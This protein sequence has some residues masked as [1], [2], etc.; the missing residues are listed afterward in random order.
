M[1]LLHTSTTVCT[2]EGYLLSTESLRTPNC[3]GI[4]HEADV[5]YIHFHLPCPTN[6]V[7]TQYPTLGGPFTTVVAL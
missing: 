5:W 1:D 7:Q 4:D 3:A 6:Q 2:N